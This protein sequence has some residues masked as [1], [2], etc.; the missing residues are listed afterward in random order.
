MVNK[1]LVE[2][3]KKMKQDELKVF[4]EADTQETFA[5]DSPVRIM[6]QKH[7]RFGED[8]HHYPISFALTEMYIALSYAL[9][10]RL[11]DMTF[12]TKELCQAI[13]RDCDEEEDN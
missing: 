2:E 4:I 9:Y 8:P 3:F 12:L 6:L 5:E 1:N 11:D 10:S 13:L 7:T